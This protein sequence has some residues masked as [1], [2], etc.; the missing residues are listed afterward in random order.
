[1]AIG[2]SRSLNLSETNLNLKEAIQKLYAPGIQDD[3]DLFS[4]S[5][6]ITSNIVSGPET[7]ENSQIIGL[8]SETL[9]NPDN[10][11]I[12]RTKFITK[13]NTWSVGDK[14]WFNKYTLPKSNSA[15]AVNPIFS[16]NGSIPA[17]R[18][19][20]SGGGYYFKKAASGGKTIPERFLTD[21][22][23]I[24]GVV[25]K[26]DISKSNSAR[27]TVT[28]KPEPGTIF[29]SSNVSTWKE[30]GTSGAVSAGTV[31]AV[32][33]GTSTLVVNA[34]G[35][36]SFVSTSAVQL[37]TDLVIEVTYQ[38]GVTASYT[39]LTSSQSAVNSTGSID[40]APIGTE[41]ELAH[42]TKWTGFYTRRFYVESIVLTNP[43]SGYLIG[44]KIEIETE[45]TVTEQS[46]SVSCVIDR[47][48]GKEYFGF[49]PIV[50]ADYYRFEVRSS[51]QT[52]FYLFDP[53]VNKFVF[54]D[55]EK[56]EDDFDTIGSREIRLFRDDS[57]FVNNILQLRFAQS[58][59]YHRSY[60]DAFSAGQNIAGAV[61]SLTS[62]ADGLRSNS[63]L[64]I[65]NTKNP[66][67]VTS[68][69]NTLGFRYNRILGNN[70]AVYQRVVMRD[71]D[72][73][74][75]TNGITGNRLKNEVQMT[76][77]KL[78]DVS[79]VNAGSFITGVKY[80]ILAVNDTDFVSIG[81][82]GNTPGIEF[83]ATGPGT[84]TGVPGTAT[85][86]NTSGP[87]SR[88]PGLF[89]KV[90][91]EYKRAFSTR[92]KPFLQINEAGPGVIN[93]AVVGPYPYEEYSLFAAN[94]SGGAW[95]G[96]NTI[97][98]KFAQRLSMPASTADNG[99]NGALYFHKNSAPV[100][101]TVGSG[102]NE[103]F[104]VP[105]FTFIS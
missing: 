75:G 78:F 79:T 104:E 35:T 59:I 83:V 39:I 47:Q 17:T 76:Q 102:A 25:L 98:S 103:Y 96:Y 95:Y 53:I 26:G 86:P 57:I 84:T 43:G 64:S 56:D 81:A 8:R 46:N 42:L 19:I 41:E 30:P 66:E 34:D 18:M 22:V 12:K 24:E 68:N 88:I 67:E 69:E 20:Y 71:Q 9:K 38:N 16:I 14:V 74:L 54:L 5:S 7:D 37:A 33:G 50:L 101:T 91:S 3:I 40:L 1:M 52:G 85:T 4:L 11:V 94:R 70:M 29:S 15:D 105:L 31:A 73:V 21:P 23:V 99:K 80:T 93:P 10:S 51:S 44:E 92:D 77:F 58:V 82:A 97:L 6:Q 45:T 13:S 65:Q 72:F 100:V 32:Q 89:I 62:I 36:W 27:A 90:G 48:V 63:F 60:N 28:F 87:F 55:L 61:K 2:L 49:D